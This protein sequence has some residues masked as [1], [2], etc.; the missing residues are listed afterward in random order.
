M[1]L[2]TKEQRRLIVLNHLGS[3]A[4]SQSEAAALLGL[5]ERQLRRLRRAYAAHGA[6][7]LAHGNRGRRPSNAIDPKLKQRVVHL[8]RSRYE[9]FNHQHLTEM[10]TE[11]EGPPLPRHR[12]PDPH[13]GR[14]PQSAPTAAASSPSSTGTGFRGRA[15]S[16]RSTAA[17]TIGWKAEAHS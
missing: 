16:C 4:P 12:P 10:L 1:T 11:R 13:G 7:A 6:K 3:G 14:D 15:C 5:C 8:A 2:S 9:G 17:D